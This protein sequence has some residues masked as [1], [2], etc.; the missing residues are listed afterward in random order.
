MP[1]PTAIRRLCLTIL[2]LASCL[3][4][5]ARPREFRA[6]WMQCV[7]GQW[8]GLTTAQQQAEMSRHLD[9]LAA[10]GANAVIFQV[11]AEC[12]AL[13]ASPYEPWSRFLTGHQG[14][15]PQPYW[16][17]LEWITQQCHQRGME[18]HAW[19]NPFRA[20]V[21]SAT[22]LASNHIALRRPDLIFPYDGLYIL[23]PSRPECREYICRIAAD[24]CRR[25]D[26]DGFHIDDYFYPY[27]APGCVIPDQQQYEADTR[28]LSLQDWRRDNVNRFICQLHDSVKAVKPYLLFGVSPFGIYR[29]GGPIHGLQNYDDLYADPIAWD[30]QGWVDYL[31]PQLYWEVGHAVADYATLLRWWDDNVTVP[32]YIGEDIRR[33][34]E[35]G[36]QHDKLATLRTGTRHVQGTVLWYS[37][38]AADDYRGYATALRTRYWAAPVLPAAPLITHHPSPLPAPRKPRAIWTDDGPV[39]CWQQPKKAQPLRYAVYQG[40]SLVAVTHHTYCP[41]PY[42]ATRTKY[43][44]YIYPLDRYRQPGQPAKRKVKL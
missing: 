22:T 23:D 40:D 7:N 36:Q 4:L 20:K 43:T 35:A 10:A 2:L 26:I 28:G 17:P 39:L 6:A 21:K 3:L 42:H 24:I 41:L 38:L 25:Y 19:I 33:T 27:P 31:A 29:N 44:Y 14:Q 8:Q 18:I 32:L 34:A 1:L 11:R 30:R 9:A 5:P 15:A 16:D 12:D 13:Y 37:R